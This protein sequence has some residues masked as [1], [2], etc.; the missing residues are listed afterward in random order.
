LKNAAKTI[1]F[2]L[3]SSAVGFSQ[4]P[5]QLGG[6]SVYPAGN[7]SSNRL[8]MLQS[9]SE[10]QYTDADGN[11]VQAKLD[12]IC[13]NGKLAAIALEPQVRIQKTAT[14]FAGPVPTIR[15]SFS[16][17]AQSNRSETWAVFDDGRT[18]SPNSELSQAKLMRRWVASLAGTQKVV[19]QLAG[20]SAGQ[21][22]FATGQLSEA[23]TSV[24]CS[25]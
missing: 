17:D 12:I 8:V 9:A 14:S 3:V 7:P 16:M 15:V 24:G 1:I 18:L 10:Q 5:K 11:H 22:S 6:W 20:E 19:F 13:K 21:S 4:T 2:V 23:L 25:Y